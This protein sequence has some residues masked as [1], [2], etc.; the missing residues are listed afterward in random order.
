MTTAF[1]LSGGASLGAVEVGMLGALA[2]AGI[3]PDLLVG[4]SVGA[5]NAAYVAGRPGVAG[6]EELATIW[7]GLNRD[8]V[9]P[10]QP[11]LGLLGFVGKR[12][13]LVANTAIRKLI[14]SNVAF[15][16]L[17]D[18]AT[19]L[20]VVATEVIG[21]NDVVF[22]TGDA[23]DAILASAAI[24]GVFPPVVIDGVPYMDGGVTE[25]SPIGHAVGLHADIVYVLPTGHPCSLKRAPR[26]ALGMVLQALTVLVG[27]Q[28]VVDIER[29]RNVVDL[30]VIPPLCPLDVS[31]V[32]FEHS[33]EMID[34]A[35]DSTAAWLADGEPDQGQL[36]I[37]G[38]HDH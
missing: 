8:A 7:R 18:A 1:A 20:H 36:H 28:L 10:I 25:N 32:D 5:L 16:R 4:T 26:G 22:S 29:Y 13:H 6:V 14:A 31:P 17:E 27:R 21:G 37:L 9:F 30:R 33:G 34:R 2:E 3:E 24:P 35:H 23:V 11:L 19:P 15:E 12:D 38:G